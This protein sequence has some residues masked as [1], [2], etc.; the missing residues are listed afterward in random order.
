MT[1]TDRLK[2]QTLETQEYMQAYRLRQ[3]KI[4]KQENYDISQIRKYFSTKFCSFVQKTTVLRCAA[5]CCIYLTYAKLTETQTSGTNFAT[6][7]TVQSNVEFNAVPLRQIFTYLLNAAKLSRLT[8][9]CVLNERGKFGVKIFSHYTE[10]V[11]F[12]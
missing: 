5:L 2:L 3:N 12:M 10:I 7:Q 9:H 1:N 11:I 6:V 4:P 8:K